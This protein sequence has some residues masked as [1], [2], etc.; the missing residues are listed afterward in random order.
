MCQLKRFE[1]GDWRKLVWLMLCSIHGLKQSALEWYEQ[2]C[3]VMSDLGFVCTESD[4]ALFY[5]DS[6]DDLTTGVTNLTLSALPT[7]VK[8]LIGWHIED[9]MG[10]SNS[11]SFLERVKRRIVEKF[12]IKDLGPVLK[13][14]GVQFERDRKTHQL[15]MHQGKYISF[16]LQEYGLSNCNPVCLP[17]NPKAPFGDP[18]ASY[19]E[20]ANLHLSYLKLIRELIY[21]SVN[22]MY[23]VN[24]LAQF[25]ADPSPCQKRVL[26]YLAGTL[27]H[28]LH[29]GTETE[30]PELHAYAD[31][32]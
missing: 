17:A 2:V 3:T 30:T 26:C 6:K 27:N 22:I 9:G 1:Q 28:H 4:H 31:A 23:I 8:C 5:Y 15:W 21:L 32:S 10:V 14:L 7:K 16:L 25:N 18:A 20:V 29:Y 12:G 11:H 19:P 24:S 13:Y